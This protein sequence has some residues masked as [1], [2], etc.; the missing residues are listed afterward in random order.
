LI[1]QVGEKDE[2][3]VENGLQEWFLPQVVSRLVDDVISLHR[4]PAENQ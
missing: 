3:R 2:Q 1:G 4:L